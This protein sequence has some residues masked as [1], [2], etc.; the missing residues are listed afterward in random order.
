MCGIAGIVSTEKQAESYIYSLCQAIHHRGPD[1]QGF[2]ANETNT[3]LLGHTRL[4]IIDLSTNANQPFHSA[5]GRHVI[6]FNGEIYN[7]K[8]IRKELETAHQRVFMTQSDTE[9]I[10]HA[11]SVWGKKMVEKLNGMFALAIYDKQ[12]RLLYLFRDR[13]G[14]KPLYYLFRDN[15]FLFASEIKALLK[16]PG[17]KDQLTIDKKSISR[18][19]HLG[20]IPDPDTIYQE[21]KSF[22]S[23]HV[24]TIDRKLNIQLLPYWNIQNHLQNPSATIT[25]TEVK[26][27]LSHHLERAVSGRLIS[28]VPLGAFLSGGTDSSLVC[29]IASRLTSSPLNTFNIGFKESKFDESQYAREVAKKLGTAHTEY[30]LSEID[31]QEMLQQYLVHFDEPFADTSVIPTMLVSK[32]ARQKVTVA[33][34]GDGGDELFQGYGAYQWANRLNKLAWKL[35]RKPIQ[36]ALE[37]TNQSK[38]LRISKMLDSVPTNKMRSH[39][40]SQEQYFFSQA[41]IE[42]QLLKQ[43]IFSPFEYD[44]PPG[45]AENLS[46]GERQAL[47]DFHFYLKDDLLVKVDRASMFYALECRCPLLDYQLVEFAFSLPIKMK[48]RNGETKWVLKEILRQYLPNQLV[49]RRKWGFG[50]PLSKWLKTDLNFLMNLL[51]E[52]N[53]EKTNIFQ[54]NYVGDL[55]KRFEGGEDY[56][57][58]RIWVLIALQNFLIGLREK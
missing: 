36:K 10:V 25:D 51:S 49:D 26:K 15:T 33:L 18:F 57:Y 3:V 7:F 23:G 56:L 32:L 6:V 41:E 58:N 14:K 55:V 29:A 1:A 50:V 11:F 8:T 44:D 37:L 4:S 39:I 30:I 53:I 5:D 43:N 34:T 12:D 13:V 40:F 45:V 16:Y 9:V 2:F 31:A 54:Y 28:D 46:A 52:E 19:L 48:V 27:M 17:I 38:W 20:Y 24:G 47:F 21:I 22:P 35:G 42:T